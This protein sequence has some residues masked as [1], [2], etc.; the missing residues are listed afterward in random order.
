MSQKNLQLTISAVTKVTKG[1]QSD[2]APSGSRGKRQS[3]G[4]QFLPI[5]GAVSWHRLYRGWWSG[6]ENW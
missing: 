3:A 4:L 2:H 1:C 5:P 6:H